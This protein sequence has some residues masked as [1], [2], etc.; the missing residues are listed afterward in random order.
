VNELARDY[1]EIKTEFVR[2]R[3]KETSFEDRGY[4]N[5][6]MALEIFVDRYMNKKYISSTD[7]RYFNEIS[8]RFPVEY[9]CIEKEMREGVTTS[10][11]DFINMQVE[12]DRA[13][14][15]REVDFEEWRLRRLEEMKCREM[16]L[17]EQWKGL[18]GKD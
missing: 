1:N 6:L 9:E 5:A 2:D 12:H 7:G 14:R 15:Q 8:R 16:E 13:E 11:S 18:G 17:R 4:I 3:L 10:F